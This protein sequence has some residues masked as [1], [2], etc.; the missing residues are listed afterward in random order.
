MVG[1]GQG[2][3]SNLGWMSCD[4]GNI[5]PWWGSRSV[6]ISGLV[7]VHSLRFWGTGTRTTILRIEGLMVVRERSGVMAKKGWPTRRT[8]SVVYWS[9]SPIHK[10]HV[11]RRMGLRMGIGLCLGWWKSFF[12]VED[13]PQIEVI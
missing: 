10:R 7:Q 11:W 13:P 12:P 2:G 8:W 3:G 1:S 6:V 9:G 4:L 5:A